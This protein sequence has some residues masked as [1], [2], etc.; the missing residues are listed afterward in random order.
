MF[1]HCFCLFL[2]LIRQNSVGQG[3]IATMH[4]CRS[5]RLCARALVQGLDLVRGRL[6]EAIKARGDK[7]PL[8]N[9]GDRVA[10]RQHTSKQFRSSLVL[11]GPPA[12]GGETML[13]R[14]L[15]N[16][17]V[18]SVGFLFLF[19]ANGGLQNLQV[20]RFV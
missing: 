17:L 14:N 3:M 9:A 13:S 10:V 5:L 1:E 2:H 11:R 6:A 15:K 20:G 18:V 4:M 8:H 12:F 7:L 19:T 16:T